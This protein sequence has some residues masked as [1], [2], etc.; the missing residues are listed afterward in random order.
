MSSMTRPG[1]LRS[2]VCDELMRAI[3][4]E[5]SSHIVIA[6]LSIESQESWRAEVLRNI[7]YST[8]EIDDNSFIC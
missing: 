3:N 7:R 4:G 8:N 2:G 5:N 1:W 6:F